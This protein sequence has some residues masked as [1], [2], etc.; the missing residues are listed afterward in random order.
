MMYKMQANIYVLKYFRKIKS[1]LNGVSTHPSVNNY[2]A[3]LF[4]NFSHIIPVL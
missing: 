2:V 1:Y 4:S 3:V